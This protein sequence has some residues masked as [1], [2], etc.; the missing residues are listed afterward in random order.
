MSIAIDT[1]KTIIKLQERGFTREQAEG[2]VEVIT[3][4]ELLTKD[5]FEARLYRAL[6]VHGLATVGAILAGATLLG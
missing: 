6:L 3:E 5:Y 2:V 4:S 1:H